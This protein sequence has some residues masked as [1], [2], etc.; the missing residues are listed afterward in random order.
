MKTSLGQKSEQKNKILKARVALA[1]RN[2]FGT[3]PEEEIETM[4][5]MA[6][7]LYKAVL[8]TYYIKKQQMKGGQPVLF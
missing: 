3:V 5:C 4:Y 8:G 1:V 7:V 6:R 2:E